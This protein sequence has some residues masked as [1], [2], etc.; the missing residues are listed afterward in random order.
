[1]LAAA[2]E[3]E[4]KDIERGQ[5]RTEKKPNILKRAFKG[6]SGGAESDEEDLDDESIPDN[7]KQPELLKFY[8]MFAKPRRL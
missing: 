4:Q 5:T 1:M 2:L 8:K 3:K 7:Y 6:L